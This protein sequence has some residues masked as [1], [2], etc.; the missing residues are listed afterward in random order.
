MAEGWIQLPPDSTGK[1][2]RTQ[3]LTVA[4]AD[5]HQPV[6]SL[7]DAA[8]ELAGPFQAGAVPTVVQ[9]GAGVTIGT[10]AHPVH[11]DG[12]AAT[13]PVSQGGPWVSEITDG[14]N[15][16]G[17]PTHP[18][19]VDPT[20]TTR[21]P[22]NLE[23]GSGNP[24]VLVPTTYDN[25]GGWQTSALAGVLTFDATAACQVIWVRADN[26]SGSN[27]IATFDPSGGVPDATHGTPLDDG[28]AVPSEISSG[29]VKVYCPGAGITV[30]VW[31]F[32]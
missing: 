23:D 32:R 18:V 6:E 29:V 20:G 4:G 9:D 8:G 10:A 11:V 19:K 13:Q 31:G 16:L 15:V 7:A 22:V 24:V 3:E 25:F 27:V 5:V 14:T 21:Q 17:T 26:G 2:S 30:K 28:I 1:K 12:S